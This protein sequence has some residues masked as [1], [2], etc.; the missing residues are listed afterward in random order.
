MRLSLFLAHKSRA[1]VEGLRLQQEYK[2]SVVAI[3][4]IGE[5]PPSNSGSFLCDNLSFYD[6]LAIIYVPNMDVLEHKLRAT[7]V[8]K[9]HPTR[10]IGTEK[11]KP[12]VE[13]IEAILSAAKSVT[14]VFRSYAGVISQLVIF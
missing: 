12:E 2:I 8:E 13:S 11:T 7:V 9:S 10:D 1:M 5:S 3:G 4:T 14:T 6:F